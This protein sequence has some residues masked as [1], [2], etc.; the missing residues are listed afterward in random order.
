MGL[1]RAVR[2]CRQEDPF[3]ILVPSQTSTPGGMRDAL[4]VTNDTVSCV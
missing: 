3:D 4:P 1:I 2:G